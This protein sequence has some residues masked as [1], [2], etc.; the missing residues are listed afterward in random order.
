MPGQQ[1]HYTV[2]D[3]HCDTLT[4]LRGDTADLRSCRLHYN[5]EKQLCYG[6]FLQVTALWVDG[7]QHDVPRRVA[8]YLDVFDE[9]VRRAG[10]AVYP[11][12]SAADLTRY[13][14]GNGP[15]PDGAHTA[16][17]LLGIEGG[18]AVGSSLERLRAL[19]DRGVR[20]LTLTWNTPNAISDTHCSAR[21]PAGLTAFGRAVVREMNARGMIVDVSHISDAGFWDVLE[22]ARR[23]V[24][25][26]HSDARAVCPHSRNLTDGMFRALMQNGGVAGIN[27]CRDFLGGSED[28]N[29]ILRHIEHFCALGGVGH[30]GIGS[31][32]DGIDALPDGIQG[33]ESLYKIPEALLR[34]NYTEEQVEGIAWRN[35]YRA[36]REALTPLS[37]DE[38][39]EEGTV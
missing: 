4:A 23:P 17:L 9:Q 16:A 3:A 34:L 11:I 29:Q 7:G 30:V 24:V 12:R 31:D 39:P 6:R 25:A 10:A 20:L 2:I 21:V 5:L 38:N 33:T 13:F 22:N 36:M 26:S 19:Y 18:D 35:F 14:T 28:L 37:D 1:E 32:F 8:Q 27:F 15:E